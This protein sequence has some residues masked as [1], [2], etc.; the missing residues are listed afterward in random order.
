MCRRPSNSLA[1]LQDFTRLH[2]D[3]LEYASLLLAGPQAVK[4]LQSLL[5]EI[6]RTTKVCR[7]LQEEIIRTHQILSLSHM[8]DSDRIE[9]TYFDELD[10][11]DPFVE[12][13]SLMTNVLTD[14]LNRLDLEPGQPLSDYL[15]AA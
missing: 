2:S 11:T 10:P 14:L 1:Q 4:Q 8:H 12:E 7:R 9:V 13:I 5:E 6:F 15:L 3:A